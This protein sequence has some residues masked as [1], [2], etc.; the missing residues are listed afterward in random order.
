MTLTVTRVRKYLL[1]APGLALAI[2]FFFVPFAFLFTVSLTRRET[3]FFTPDYTFANYIKTWNSYGLEFQVTLGMAAAAAIVDVV[4]GFPF[5]YIMIRK[6]RRF[7]DLFRSILLVPLFGELYIAFGLWYLF[8]PK[9]PL[10]FVFEALGIP[11]FEALYSLPSAVM[12]LAIFTFPFA[13]LQIGVA[14]NQ[15]D[16]VLEEAAKCLGAGSLRTLLKVTIPLSSPGIVSGWLM[17]FGWNIGAYAIP[18]LMG[19]QTYGLNA[20]ALKIRNISLLMMNFGLA[21]A[22]AVTLVLVG[23]ATSYFSARFSRGALL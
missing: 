21:S 20:L 15:L 18:V 22:L 1:L 23:A 11:V 3:F 13:V 8:L 2:M 16:P 5:A 6:V 17:A 12:G 10:A 7:G 19:G 14:L 4:L 9:G